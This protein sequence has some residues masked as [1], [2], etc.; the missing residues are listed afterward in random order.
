MLHVQVYMYMQQFC[1]SALYPNLSPTC[2]CTC[3]CICTCTYTCIYVYSATSIIRTLFI[4]NLNYRDKLETRK[5]ITRMH[6]RHIGQWSFED[7]VMGWA[8]SYRL[9]LA[10][11]D[12]PVYFSE[13]CW[14]CSYSV[15]IV[16]RLGIINQVRQRGSDYRGCTVPTS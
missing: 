3:T 10:K 6:R 8:M 14:P 11:T 9:A 16:N 1:L 15:G 2:T 7:V 13:Y 5:Y 4:Q 12:W